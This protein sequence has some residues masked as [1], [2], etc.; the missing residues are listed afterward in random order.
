MNIEAIQ[1]KYSILKKEALS[2]I[3]AEGY[4]LRHK[5][6]GAHVV[7]LP[8]QDDN[9]VFNIAFRTTPTDSTGVA[10]IIEHT[11]LCGSKA[12]PVKDPFVELVKGSLN[13]FLNAMTY[14]DK[15]MYPVA[16]TND[17]DFRNLI[18]VY[19]DAVFYP[20]IYQ[21]ENIFKQEGWHFELENA[22]DELTYNGVVYNEMKGVYSSP[23]EMLDSVTTKVLFPD[24]TYGVESGG[25][26]DAIPSLTYEDYLHFHKRYYHPSNSYIYLYG[27]VNMEETLD[28][29][30]QKYLSHFDEIDP[31]SDITYQKPFA[32]IV[33]YE[34]DYP[35]SDEE[36]ES[37]KTY[38]SYHV[39]CGN[40]MDMKESLALDVLDYAL[41]SMPGAPVKQALIDAGIGNDIFGSYTDG[42]LQP[43]FSVVAKG[44]E[45]AD[46]ERFVDI[47][48][49]ALTQQAEN[50]V[51][52]DSLLAGINSME[53]QFREADY[54]QFP[55]GLMY[56][57]DIM[58]T[59]LYDE[60][61]PFIPLC[62]SKAYEE[63]RQAIGS[64][65]FENLI[66]EK[67]LANC[68]GALVILK[69]KKGLQQEKEAQIKAQLASYKNSLSKEEI[70]ALIDQTKALRDYQEAPE[71]AEDLA[72]L[73]TLK[74]EDIRK[75]VMVLSNVEDAV[76]V[77]G[78]SIPLI[79]HEVET[80]GIGYVD[81]YWDLRHIPENMLPYAALLKEVLFNLD[82]T[83]HSYAQLNNRMNMETGGIHA[84]ISSMENAVE[85]E[86]YYGFFAI[87]AK[88]LYNRLPIAF[89]LIKEVLND[90]RFE[91][92]KRLYEILAEKES[93]MQMIMLRAGNAAASLRASAYISSAGAFGEMLGGISYYRFIKNLK[94]NFEEMKG[95]IISKLRKVLNMI[96]RPEN[97]IVSYTTGAEGENAITQ[98]ISKVVIFNSE[99]ADLCANEILV[100]P[101]GILNE[102]FMTSGQV[103]FVAQVGNYRASGAAYS[104]AMQIYRQIMSYEY[105]W[106]NVRVKGGAYG[107]GASL[108]KN[109][110]GTMTS[111]RDPNLA[112]TLE[113][114]AKTPQYLSSF[115]ADEAEM[116]KYIIGTMSAV[117][118]PL[119]PSM[120]GS[121]SMRSYISGI[122]PLMRQKTRDEILGANAKDIQK[123]SKAVDAIIKQKAYCV[124]GAEQA[125]RKDEVLFGSIEML[126]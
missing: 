73:P 87:G 101:L 107:C 81:L 52:A 115:E 18:H 91:D 104:G 56:G 9:K 85:P 1:N 119:T 76:T 86:K 44:A 49:K 35:I 67:F 74:I 98:E 108:A 113:I 20:N 116:T 93:S 68:H 39:V 79:R 65:Y 48:K 41:F 89:D 99:D 17:T 126:M 103:Q 55:K 21:T 96:I 46:A 110:M 58:D 30:D 24:T 12:F 83:K 4:L 105:L 34:Q 80:N 57:I 77:N 72:C 29:I 64:G 14:P 50:G 33:R 19:L 6:S 31:D 5:K 121:V 45:L 114:Y 37:K 23:D 16:S 61:E 66:R 94:A 40:P 90:T 59:W 51:D 84:G 53:F 38:L 82:T 69:P 32:Q 28:F 122:T 25:D 47:L 124:I 36:D 71:S 63:L 75:H 117:D 7:L 106:Q 2:D 70:Q 88:A 100:Q 60:N 10:H 26:P 54:S 42:I 13:T 27:D 22:E 118:T 109:G 111:Y 95:E 78:V 43:Y 112:K 102:G 8:C 125:I 62:Q 3:H 123:L 97:L 92:E 15:T 120:Y 11:V